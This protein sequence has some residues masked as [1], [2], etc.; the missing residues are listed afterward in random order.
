MIVRISHTS[1][2]IGARGPPGLK[3][4][5][6]DHDLPDAIVPESKITSITTIIVLTDYY[7]DD[8]YYYYYYDCYCYHYYYYSRTNTII[9]PIPITVTITISLELRP[10]R[11]SSPTRATVS[12]QLGETPISL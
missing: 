8:H 1:L 4:L 5:P 12:P 10:A 6:Y 2:A 7:H 3:T 9:I 11:P